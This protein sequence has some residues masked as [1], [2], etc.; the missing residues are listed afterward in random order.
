MSNQKEE[1]LSTP[2]DSVWPRHFEMVYFVQKGFQQR[3]QLVPTLYRVWLHWQDI[4]SSGCRAG[5]SKVV[6]CVSGNCNWGAG[7]CW[8]CAVELHFLSRACDISSNAL[9]I[10]TAEITLP[11]CYSWSADSSHI[12]LP[13]SKS[14]FILLIFKGLQSLLPYLP[15]LKV[16]N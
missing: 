6:N 10:M 3:M 16:S 8:Q 4:V 13:Y 14:Q 2:K 7:H 9:H 15:F 12:L 5:G 11:L 1:E